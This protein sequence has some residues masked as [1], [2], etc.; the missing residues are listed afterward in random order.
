MKKLFLLAG[1]LLLTAGSVFA[2]SMPRWGMTSV[3][4]YIEENE[5]SGAV[6]RAFNEWAQASNGKLRFRFY[7][8]RFASNNAPIKI[9]FVNERAPYYITRSKRHETTGYFANMEDGYINSAR[10]QV[11]TLNRE[12]KPVTEEDDYD[13]ML[14]EVGYILGLEKIFGYC[15]QPSVMCVELIGKTKGLT[16]KDKEEIRSKYER[17]SDDIKEKKANPNRNN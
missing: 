6:Q 15:E 12:E 5:F 14:L 8:T 7:T 13:N 11:Y 3:D 10:I 9:V 17:S 1:I 4:V 16:E 2:Y